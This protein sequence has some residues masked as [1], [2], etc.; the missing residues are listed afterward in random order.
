MVPRIFE[1][2]E[3]IKV[4]YTLETPGTT[5]GKAPALEVVGLAQARLADHGVVVEGLAEDRFGVGPQL[6]RGLRAAEGG[7]GADA[8]E[9]AVVDLQAALEAPDQAGQ[10]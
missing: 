6:G 5:W 2:E 4:Y 1:E 3:D 7:R 9:R 8:A 10:I